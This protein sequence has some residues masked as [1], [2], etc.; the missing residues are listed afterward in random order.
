MMP[1]VILAGGLAQRLRPLTDN[2]PKSLILINNKPFVDWQLHLLREKGITKVLFCLSYKSQMI[3]NHVG[4]G[5]RYDLDIK[6]SLDGP[7]ALGTGGA[8]KK[9]LPILE[10][11]FMVLYGDSYLD[12]NY[13]QTESVFLSCDKPAMMTVYK[14]DGNYDKSNIK[15]TKNRIEKYEKSSSDPN[16]TYIDYGLSFFTKEVFEQKMFVDRFDLSDLCG[17]LIEND[18]M[19]GHEVFER[20]Y[21]IG[22]YKGIKD[23]SKHLKGSK[24]VI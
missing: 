23:I 4:D 2:I 16:L 14:N 18:R 6:Y 9:A 19:Y 8:I 22:S 11:K 10:N 24:N 1:I 5:S 7:E 17:N 12:L 21:E 3:E 20:Y 13:E 15:F